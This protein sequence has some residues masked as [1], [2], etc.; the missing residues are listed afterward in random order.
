MTTA[1]SCA[2]SAISFF[3]AALKPVVPITTL[4]PCLRHAARFASVPSGRV[5]STS[6][7]PRGMTCAA[8]SPIF[9]P[10]DEPTSSP[11]SFPMSGL[12]FSSSAAVSLRSGER[13]TASM[14]ARPIR[15]AAPAIAIFTV[16][17]CPPSHLVLWRWRGS[18]RGLVHDG[19]AFD[20]PAAPQR[21]H[22]ALQGHQPVVL[23]HH[24]DPAPLLHLALL[25]EHVDVVPPVL[26][27][28]I[29]QERRAERETHLAACHARLELGDHILRDDVALLDFRAVRGEQIASGKK[30]RSDNDAAHVPEGGAPPDCGGC[31]GEKTRSAR[32]LQGGEMRI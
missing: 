5:K 21:R 2:A 12:P 15:P 10:Q 16:A 4:T 19:A 23:E 22:I 6:T 8:A 29:H 20:G 9:T 31:A 13:S 18:C 27:E 11:A 24:H 26:P 1:M 14:R 7:A 28:R 32:G 30:Q 25:H 3:C 17:I